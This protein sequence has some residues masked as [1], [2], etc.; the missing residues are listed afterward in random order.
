M[1]QGMLFHALRDGEMWQYGRIRSAWRS[2]ASTPAGCAGPG[3]R[4]ARGTRCC[5]PDLRGAICPERRSRWVYRSAPLPFE[6]EDR[7]TRAATMDDEGPDRA[8]RRR[9]SR[10]RQSIRL[11]A[12]RRCSGFG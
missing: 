12:A 3:R 7:R 11:V 5:G 4:S 1:Q 10:A 9:A 6:E 8:D 2:A